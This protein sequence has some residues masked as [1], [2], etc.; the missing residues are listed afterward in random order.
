M[1]MTDGTA[2]PAPREAEARAPR[3]ESDRGSARRGSHRR[4]GSG[5][6]SP[7]RSAAPVA[8]WAVTRAAL[9]LCVFKVVTLPGPDFT[10]DV[11]VIYQGWYGVLKSGVFPWNDVT[12]QYPPAA[13]LAVL[14]P[15]L[16]PFLDYPSAFYLL[17]CAADAVVLC[18]LLRTSGRPGRRR[19]GVWSWVAGVALLT[20]YVLTVSVSVAAGS[21]MDDALNLGSAGSDTVAIDRE[22]PTV[23]VDIVAS[24]L[25]DSDPSSTV[26]FTFSEAPV[27]FEADDIS[28]VGGTISDLA[29]TS[30]PLVYTATFTADDGFSGSGSIPCGPNLSFTAGSCSAFCVSSYSRSM[31]GRGV[32][33]GTRMPIQKL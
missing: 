5:T 28:A 25:S 32:P 23:T 3:D 29:V 6:R 13:A 2:T 30:D 24:T 17:A 15:A 21:Y 33:D 18:L 26:T 14:S 8:L 22:N 20:D 27:G 10:N 4:R 1:G 9:L 16:L 11:N 19:A 12:W 7:F 31:I